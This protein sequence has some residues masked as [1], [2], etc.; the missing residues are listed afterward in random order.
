MSDDA[1]A[2]IDAYIEKAAPFAVPILQRLRADMH[3]A[4]GD[5]VE[6]IKWSMPAFTYRGKMV[7]NMAA[8]KAHVAFGFWHGAM[9]TGGGERR[10]DAMGDSGRITHV[11][12]LPDSATIIAWARRQCA[13]IDAGVK[14]PHLAGRTKH[15]QLSIDAVPEFAA[16]LAANPTAKAH[17]DGFPPSAQREYIDW[18]ASAKR[19]ATRAQRIADALNWLADG[20][21]R[22]WKYMSC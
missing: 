18:I 17:F 13:L 7:A 1:A 5:I 11:D 15:P 21:R 8:F 19:D 2:R 16:K 12:Q 22:N 6:A 4:S 9:V 10:M 20:K 3:A 14:P